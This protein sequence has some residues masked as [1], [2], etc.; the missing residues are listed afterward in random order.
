MKPSRLAI[1]TIAFYSATLP[2]VAAFFTVSTAQA[3]W[4][5]AAT[6]T[7]N[8]ATHAYLTT[9]NW[10]AGTV[11]DTFGAGLTL[12]GATTS[13]LAGPRTTT[14]DLTFTYTGAF[15]LTVQG[16]GVLSPA[17]AAVTAADQTLTLAGNVTVNPVSNQTVTLGSGTA[18]NGLL[19]DLGA[20]TRTLDVAANKS[21]TVTNIV[22]NGTLQKNSAGTL[23]L[24]GQSTYA[25][26]FTFNAGTVI[27]Q[28]DS[29]GAV[30][31]VTSGPFGTGTVTLN[32]GTL[33][34]NSTNNVNNTKVVLNAVNVAS[35]TT[36]LGANSTLANILFSGPITGSGTLANLVTG[37]I[38][39]STVFAGDLSGFTGTFSYD[40]TNAQSNF[41]MGAGT[42]TAAVPL[43]GIT[44]DGSHAKFAINASNTNTITRNLALTDN[45]GNSTLKMGEL[46]GNGVLMGSFNN[47]AQATNTYEVGALNTSTTFSGRLSNATAGHQADFN[48]VKVG[49]G[50][51]TLSA[52]NSLYTGTT[53]IQ[54]GTIIASGSGA[55]GATSA[56]TTVSSGATLD[57][58]ANIGTEAVS[59]GGTGA[60]GNGALVAG[61]G[62]GTLGGVLT[63]TSG[64]SLGGAGSL[65][66]NGALGGAF[67]ITKV[68]AGTTTLGAANG[69]TGTTTVT[70]G[71][72]VLAVGSTINAS[73]GI[74]INGGTAKFQ[75][76][77]TAA[78]SP[79]VT[80]TQGTLEATGSIA[81]LSVAADVGNKVVASNAGGS[82]LS[83]GGSTSFSGAATLNLTTG[84]QSTSVISTPA[85][86][87]TTNGIVVNASNTSWNN[88]TYPLISYGTFSG[89]LANFTKGTISNLGARQSATLNDTGS[90]IELVIGGDAPIWTGNTSGEWTTNAI[91][92]IKNWVLLTSQTL[93]DFLPNDSVTFNDV[94]LGG[95]TTIDISTAN[96]SPITTT[97]ANNGV[98][99]GGV[100]YT[101]TSTGG[102]G[103]ATGSLVK[104]GTGPVTIETANTYSGGTFVNGGT[105]NLN[106]ASAIGT[107]TLTLAGTSPALGNTKGTPVTLSTN[108]A[109]AWNADFSFAGTSNLNL[110]T[111]AVVLGGNRTVNTTA[112]ELAVGGVISGSFSLTKT[113]AGTLVLT[114]ANTY[115]G[116]TTVSAGTLK[117]TTGSLQGTITNNGAIVFD[118]GTAG[119]YAGSIGGSGSVTKENSGALTL[120]NDSTWSGG[121]TVNAGTLILANTDNDGDGTVVGTLTANAGTTVSLTGAN[122]FGYNTLASSTTTVNLNGATLDQAVDANQGYRTN[123]VLTGGAITASV[124][125]TGSNG[126][127]F[128]PGFSITSHASATTSTIAGIVRLRDTIT[129]PITVD[130][131]AAATDLQISAVI[132]QQNAL[133]GITKAGDGTLLLTGANSYTG[134]TT[135]NGGTLTVGT[136][137]TLG[138]TTARLTVNNPNTG[139]G[140]NVTVNLPTAVDTVIGSLAGAISAPTSGVNTAV[141]NNGGS[142]RNFAVNQTVAATYAGVIAGA[143]S[144]TLG[145]S[146]TAALTLTGVNTYTGVTTVSAGT[147]EVDGS[148]ATTGL[149]VASGAT[150]R[151]TGTIAGSVISSGI[152]APGAGVGTLNTGAASLTGTL[153]IEIDGATGD[154][155]HSTGAVSLSGA[156]TVTELTGGFTQP[157]YVI[158]EGTSL[159]GTF[160]SVPAGYQVTYSA[161]QATLT[162]LGGYA[163]WIAGYPAAGA[164]VG[165]KDDPDGDG[166]VNLLE[167]V[168]GGVPAGSGAADRSILPTST[169]TATD[170]VVSFKRSD[171][172]ENDTV[173]KVQWSTD[174]NTWGAPNE[175]TIGAT[176][177]GIVT[178]AEDTPTAALD[179]ISV[180]IPRT[181][182]AGGKLFARV[183]VTQP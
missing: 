43:T 36:I 20:G 170:L 103:I 2:V 82:A 67:G 166:I 181:N 73:S 96:V 25:G 137:G 173:L 77:A 32:G 134:T 183:I 39:N 27:L 157:S 88:G 126:L 120:T 38:A 18:N 100:D 29:A 3:Q 110:G 105:L 89:T 168:L 180:A 152:I 11:S 30:G 92:G 107:G 114:G 153:A 1:R 90:A 91:P 151:G 64:A 24:V 124:A 35:G 93:T 72:L 160:S 55:L 15:N 37:S 7:G 81:G 102:F 40:N 149:T 13:Y 22:S 158:A 108:N 71:T 21:L 99:N 17:G 53:G 127:Q 47:S 175:V 95:V 62:T 115:S 122:S 132:N 121:T 150:L 147:L 176:S 41:R 58:Q 169:L 119:T 51:L 123:F 177:S 104:S 143:G 133:S 14:G 171:L 85:L 178:V 106:N 142:G 49:T 179:T 60:G 33:Y 161:T 146:S 165:P 131:G 75:Q 70:A 5:G 42:G 163:S 109:Q 182:A 118:Q 4:I 113:G 148:L 125:Q 48:L 16:G 68:G 23:T 167:Y 34:A 45:I 10:T 28:R 31:A 139:A 83:I 44:V 111:G 80:L 52:T 98:S 144:F 136:G 155:L 59:F 12:T 66:L 46:S 135:V 84:S 174:L 9:T 19:I 79:A 172:S 63:L 97:F 86:T 8:D 6:G 141:I 50:T 112:A 65:N 61:A 162:K 154:K 159:T 57:V 94:A 129:L 69:Y 140:N 145:G 56:G 138:T 128:T 76:L 156:L 54:G 117:G 74:T 78:T 26:G 116:G 87:T 164:L 101:L 130:D